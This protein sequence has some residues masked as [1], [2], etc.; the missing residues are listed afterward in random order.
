M[1]VEETVIETRQQHS[2]GEQGE[3]NISQLRDGQFDEQPVWERYTFGCCFGCCC[4]TS[5]T[6]AAARTPT[7]L[8]REDELR[9]EV[10][11]TL[12]AQCMWPKRTLTVLAAHKLTPQ[13]CVH[14]CACT[15]VKLAGGRMI[16]HK[17]IMRRA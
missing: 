14:P 16:C 11:R 5:S 13:G 17:F 2:G 1:Q 6:K 12:H 4:C 7:I 3:S 8:N 10:V 15:Y 9:D